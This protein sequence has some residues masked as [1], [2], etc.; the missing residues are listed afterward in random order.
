MGFKISLK[1]DGTLQTFKAF[2]Q[3]PG[4]DYMEIFDPFIKPITLRIIFTLVVRHGW[5]I[6]QMDVNNV[7]LNGILREKGVYDLT[8][9][10]C[11]SWKTWLCVPIC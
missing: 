1:V 10:I 7:F 3:T 11:W 6:H 5:K 9:R 2:Q 4:I 8:K